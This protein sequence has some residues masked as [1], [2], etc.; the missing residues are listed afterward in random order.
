MWELGRPLTR[1][2]S[3]P[4]PLFAPTTTTCL[5]VKAAAVARRLLVLLFIDGDCLCSPA[6]KGRQV[7]KTVTLLP[8]MIVHM[9]GAACLSSV[10]LSSHATNEG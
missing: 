1:H 7:L 5:S 4:I 8:S 3:R 2:T 10:L 6:R 9:Y